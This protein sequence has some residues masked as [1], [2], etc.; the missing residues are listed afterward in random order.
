MGLAIVYS[1]LINT[2]SQIL[3]VSYT[4]HALDQFLTGISKY[5][6]SIVRIGNQSKNENLDRFNMKQLCESTVADK[7]VKKSLFRLKLAYSEGVREF[8]NLQQNS[9]N[10]IEKYNK[11]YVRIYYIYSYI[12]HTV[13]ETGPS[14]FCSFTCFIVVSTDNTEKTCL[15]GISEC[16]LHALYFFKFHLQW[17]NQTKQIDLQAKLQSISRMQEEIRQISEYQT[18]RSKRII[19]MTSTGA[20]RCNVL[21]QLLQTPIGKNYSNSKKVISLL[22]SVTN[23]NL[24]ELEQNPE[25][26]PEIQNLSNENRAISFFKSSCLNSK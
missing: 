10:T 18:I 20:A 11:I 26:I 15:S 19:G 17:L 2:D 9:L 23:S 7:R 21:L 25:K 5:T 3:I 22:P 14:P 24:V 13:H 1:L 8:K 16:S 4:N 6:D 12:L